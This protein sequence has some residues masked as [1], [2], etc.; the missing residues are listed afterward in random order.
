MKLRD[1]IIG[2]VI[3]TFIACEEDKSTSSIEDETP[4][5]TDLNLITGVKCLNQSGSSMT[6]FGNPNEKTRVALPENTTPGTIGNSHENIIF[7]PNPFKDICFINSSQ[8]IEEIWLVKGE[9]HNSFQTVNFENVSVDTTGLGDINTRHVKAVGT[10]ITALN[11]SKLD[12]G[13]YKI[14]IRTSLDELA[15]IPAYKLGDNMSVDDLTD[16]FN[17]IWEE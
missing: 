14:I 9:A 2:T 3:C 6:V 17:E 15:F 13:F 10:G 8:T 11:L 7:Y 4:Q 12:S 1:V 16:S 5:E